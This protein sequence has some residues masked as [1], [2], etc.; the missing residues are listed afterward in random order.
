VAVLV[1]V[2]VGVGSG[3]EVGV[4][5]GVLVGVGVSVGV[6]EEVGVGVCVD[7]LVGLGVLVSIGTS[8]VWL[9]R[10]LAVIVVASLTSSS[11]REVPSLQ[12]A[13]RAATTKQPKIKSVFLFIS[14]SISPNA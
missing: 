8:A 14:P 9:A 5:V 10:V 7:V 11:A 1:A 6:G 13:R 3:V 2:G 12:A 4:D